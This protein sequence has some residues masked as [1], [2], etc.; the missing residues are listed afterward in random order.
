MC[1]LPVRRANWMVYE[2][3]DPWRSR[4]FWHNAWNRA[5]TLP[6]TEFL[7][8]KKKVETAAYGNINVR[9]EITLLYSNEDSFKPIPENLK[10]SS[11]LYVMQV[12]TWMTLILGSCSTRT[13]S[14]LT[15]QIVQLGIM[16]VVLPLVK[17]FFAL[18]CT[19]FLQW[20]W[21]WAYFQAGVHVFQW[22]RG[23]M[24]YKRLLCTSVGCVQFQ[25]LI[26]IY[27]VYN[28]C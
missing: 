3:L 25:Y 20:I 5:T 16:R 8:F 18:V 21:C 26:P 12:A 11:L 15:M 1:T 22:F 23:G 19:M 4:F 9:R 7:L 14:F 28:G 10:V 2:L 27:V 24:Q 6:V 13:N 17:L